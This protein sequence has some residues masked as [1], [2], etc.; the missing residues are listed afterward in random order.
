[1]LRKIENLKIDIE[2]IDKQ[3]FEY[4]HRKQVIYSLNAGDFVEFVETSKQEIYVFNSDGEEI[5]KIPDVY[6]SQIIEFLNDTRK[7]IA[8][9]VHS[10][11]QL[12][13]SLRVIVNCSL[14]ALEDRNKNIPQKI[15]IQ[16]V[17][18]ENAI[19]N[20]IYKE[21]WKEN[22]KHRALLHET[23]ERKEQQLKERE[24][25]LKEIVK[26]DVQTEMYAL[27]TA[28]KRLED[29]TKK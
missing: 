12:K 29:K 14:F 28:N 25:N 8:A 7:D 2:D 3:N 22:E 6:Y 5:G 17:V 13:R 21:I 20:Q 19:R 15:L 24:S 1:M 4:S 11:K 10:I 9:E 18:D 16:N 26:A 23:F 27:Q